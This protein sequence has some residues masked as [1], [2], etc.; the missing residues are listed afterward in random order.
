M[1]E[2]E[3]SAR[4]V[5]EEIINVEEGGFLLR[6]ERPSRPEFRAFVE[7]EDRVELVCEIGVHEGS[8]LR[9]DGFE[10]YELELADKLLLFPFRLVAHEVDR[11]RRFDVEV[12]RVIPTPLGNCF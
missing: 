8:V 9:F 12:D 6:I 10:K 2:D 3:C 7:V 5:L 1:V 11:Y 4:F